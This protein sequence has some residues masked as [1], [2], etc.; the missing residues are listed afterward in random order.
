MPNSAECQ[1]RERCRHVHCFLL[2]LYAVCVARDTAARLHYQN[3]LSQRGSQLR[4]LLF[5]FM[6]ERNILTDRDRDRERQ[7][8]RD[9]ETERERETQTQTQ[10]QTGTQSERERERELSLIHI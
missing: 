10:R 9:R 2:D 1:K 6:L 7:K 5:F 8:D 4:T 3:H